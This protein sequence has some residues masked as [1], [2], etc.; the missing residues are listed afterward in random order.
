M[1]VQ[2]VAQACPIRLC[3]LPLWPNEHMRSLQESISA[4]AGAASSAAEAASANLPEPV[5]DALA[6]A[7]GPV[8]QAVSQVSSP[9]EQTRV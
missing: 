4:S 1:T 9:P 7:K 6:A 2:C 3:S 8:F 5:R